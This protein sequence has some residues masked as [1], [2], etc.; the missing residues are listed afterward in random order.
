MKA[1]KSIY[2]SS[3]GY[4]GYL[5]LPLGCWF[6]SI[7][8]FIRLPQWRCGVQLHQ[9]LL[10]PHIWELVC[11]LKTQTIL[12]GF[13][14]G[15]LSQ[16]KIVSL[17]CPKLSPNDVGTG[18]DSKE[19]ILFYFLLKNVLNFHSHTQVCTLREYWKW[20][21][22]YLGYKFWV[23]FK[24][25]KCGKSRSQKISIKYV[26]LQ[27]NSRHWSQRGQLQLAKLAPSVIN[28]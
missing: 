15:I 10:L 11:C 14:S 21:L 6:G 7:M 2:T 23:S 22:F 26:I 5:L 8:L 17:P 9:S 1:L 13:L 28:S 27:K 16:L 18:S 20:L 3:S 12:K 19:N 25:L 4:E 24:L